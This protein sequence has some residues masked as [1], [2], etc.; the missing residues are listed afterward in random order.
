MISEKSRHSPDDRCQYPL[1]LSSVLAFVAVR[2]RKG[3]EGKSPNPP[4]ALRVEQS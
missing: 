1:C 3:G 4:D 2:R